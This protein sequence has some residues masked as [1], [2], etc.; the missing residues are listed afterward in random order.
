[1]AMKWILLDC[2]HGN[3]DDTEMHH[4]VAAVAATGSS[5]IVRIMADQHWMIK[6]ALDAG[7]HGIMVSLL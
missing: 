1:M 3:I 4:C 2:E 6:R 7:V 5:P